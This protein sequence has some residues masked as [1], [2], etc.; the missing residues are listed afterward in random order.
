MS[1]WKA[2]G[3]PFV[4]IAKGAL[5]VAKYT[6]DPEVMAAIAT[7]AII[8]PGPEGIIVKTIATT[9]EGIEIKATAM[10]VEKL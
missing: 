2:V 9:V 7:V 3:M 10:K 1:F 8:I 6:K 4:Y 5:K